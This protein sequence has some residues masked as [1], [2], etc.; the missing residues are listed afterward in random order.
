MVAQRNGT[1]FELVSINCRPPLADSWY[2]LSYLYLAI[3]GTLITLV[4]GLLVS[5]ITGESL[6]SKLWFLSREKKIQSLHLFH[7]LIFAL[8]WLQTEKK[9]P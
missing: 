6:S 5:I 1:D 4:S 9:E 7:F 8:R 2:S 3:L